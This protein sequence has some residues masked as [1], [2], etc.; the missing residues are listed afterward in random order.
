MKLDETSGINALRKVVHRLDESIHD[1]DVGDVYFSNPD[2]ESFPLKIENIREIKDATSSIKSAFVDG[3]NQEILGAPN[4][5]VQINRVYFCLF[6]GNE[7]VHSKQLINRIEF[8]SATHSSFRDGRIFYDTDLFPIG[9]NSFGLPDKLDLSFDSTDRTVTIGTQRADI[10]RVASIA[11]RF[12]EWK[13]A[14]HVVENEMESGDFLVADGSL[15]SAFTN[16]P[17]YLRELFSAGKKNRVIITGLSKTSR[18]FTTTGLSL[19]GAIQ[20]IAESVPYEKWYIPLAQSKSK[21]HEA[22]IF[23]I[24]LHKSAQRIFRFEIHRDQLMNLKEIDLQK[25]MSQIAKNSKDIS[26]IGYP[27][28][29]VDGDTFARVRE[30]EVAHYKAMLMSEIS[31]AGKWKK[32][33]RHIS[34]IDAH[35]HLNMV[36]G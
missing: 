28:G 17:K 19:L 35:D 2:Y 36:V 29:L 13:L 15:E 33:S 16:E 18:L 6:R 9:K 27:Y 12:A 23:A 34:S 21:E 32:F 10:S 11:R 14:T 25:I 26:F 30:E 3:G 22:S 8:F 4:F 1:G 24:K 7:R 5:S 20:Q 31:R